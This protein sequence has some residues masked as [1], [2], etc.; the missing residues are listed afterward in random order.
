M[1][2]TNKKTHLLM[3]EDE[4][5]RF[6][7]RFNRIGQGSY[8]VVYKASP[9]DDPTKFVAIKRMRN[10]R[11]G[12]GIPVDAYREISLLLELA[13]FPHENIAFL[14]RVFMKPKNEDG[15]ATL[16]L[17]Y[18][19]YEHDLADI[20]RYHRR[21]ETAMNQSV[22]KS[23]MYQC[24]CGLRYLHSNWI[25]HR[26][27]K[28]ANILLTAHD[29]RSEPGRVKLA[30]FGLARIFRSPLRKLCD[31]GEVVTLWYRAP[32]LLLRSKHYTRAIDVWALGCIFAELLSSRAI[33]MGEERRGPNHFQDDQLR[34]IFAVLGMPS[35]ETWTNLH[36]YP[37]YKHIE[38]WNPKDF[39]LQ[40]D[41]TLRL[42]RNSNAYDL[43]SRMLQYDPVKRITAEEAMDHPYFLE[44]PR[45]SQN[46]FHDLRA[47]YAQRTPEKRAPTSV[48]PSVDQDAIRKRKQATETS[49][50]HSLKRSRHSSSRTGRR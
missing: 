10:T 39:R 34:K 4:M 3:R 36:S 26:D 41:E 38:N 30:D 20:I 43:L 1:E 42:K 12:V 44:S 49:S 9:K 19:Y 8:G 15:D 45:P 22:L 31:D 24:L 23:I 7:Q 35:A 50:D 18:D 6:Y 25:M 14:G 29:R 48:Y 28:P 17:V 16:Y 40:L 46:A 11:P 2:R 21:G 37:G 33:F 5:D 13:G 27:L 32:E 47:H